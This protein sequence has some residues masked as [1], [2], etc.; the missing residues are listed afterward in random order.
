MNKYKFI[1]NP[2]A[3]RGNA[4]RLLPK[5]EERL[6]RSDI[7]FEILVTSGRGDAVKLAH[8][9]ARETGVIVAV[10]GDGTVN[11]VVKGMYGSKAI[12][13]IIP[14]GS[15]NDFV[16][17]LGIPADLDQSLDIVFKGEHR[18]VDL[19]S[20]N[21]DIFVNSVGMGL[22]GAVAKTMNRTPNLPPSIAY[23]YGV[24]LNVLFYRNKILRWKT[25][26]DS[27]EI[28]ANLAAVMNGTT[29]G[30][31]YNIAP[32]ASIDDGLFDVVIVGDYKVLGRIMHL[33]KLKTGKHLFL[34]KIHHFKVNEIEIASDDAVPV[35]IDG[36]LIE[37]ETEGTSIHI[38][39]IRGG[40][41]VLTGPA[42]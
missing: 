2:A 31:S 41:K 5:L 15:G 38:K 34:K 29:Y 17:P 20:I 11:E 12:L 32:G 26:D 8:K 21:D 36:E 1:V 35:A 23:H 13:G 14:V 42:I 33:P 28:K 19:G 4:I 25:A 16:K 3:G 7:E 40:L 39:V 24:L 6:K 10:G 37:T 30:G 27:G 9:S 22:D 18:T